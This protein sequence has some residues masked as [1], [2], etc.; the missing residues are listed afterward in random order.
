MSD[1]KDALWVEKYRP[2]TINE[3][4]LPDSLKKTF[5]TF[6]DN[7]NIP[8]LL[9][10]GGPGVGKTTVA[11]VMLEMLDCD[12]IMINGSMSGNIDTLRNDIMDFASTM[13]F[14]G[15]RKYVI[16]DEADYLNAN[17]FQPALRNFM[18]EFSKNCGFI[19]TCNYANRI[20]KPLHSRCSLVDFK[21]NKKDK[22]SI[23]SQ[24]FKRICHIL[25]SENIEY[26]KNVVAELI[27]KYFP[28]WRRVINELQRYSVLGKIDVGI[29][30]TLSDTTFD[31]LINI[32]KKK[33]FNSM[34][35]WVADN[36]DND[37][38]TLMRKFYDKASEII[39]PSSI[40]EMVILI[41]EYQYKSAFV[42]DQEINL[43]A[44]FTELM[45]NMEWK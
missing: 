12:Y 2:K 6:V 38:V 25:D 17:S 33:E 29:L 31:E 44:L 10:S 39:K 32:L 16:L 21:I 8:N 4:I 28:D 26:D 24:F 1:L 41:A 20:I 45:V 35:K 30:E 9:L 40:P 36:T 37:S 15:G 42:V 23:A 43:A 11:K 18:V 7:K 3:L 5:Q 34:R 19:L 13:S 22:P 27:N 14:H